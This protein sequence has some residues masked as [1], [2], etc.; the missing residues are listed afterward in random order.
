[1]LSNLPSDRAARRNRSLLWT[2]RARIDRAHMNRRYM[3]C[4]NRLRIRGANNGKRLCV[5]LRMR[6]RPCRLSKKPVMRSCYRAMRQAQAG[7][8][9]QIGGKRRRRQKHKTC[10]AQNSGGLINPTYFVNLDHKEY[11][12][13]RR[14]RARRLCYLVPKKS[15]TSFPKP[16]TPL[17]LLLSLSFPDCLYMF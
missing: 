4:F 8:T 11:S 2:R 17:F 16:L 9:L 7:G 1:M 15:G 13:Q 12:Q 5:C 3:A 6:A 10:T 14:Q